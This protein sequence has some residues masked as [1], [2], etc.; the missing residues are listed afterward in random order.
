MSY[1][2]RFINDLK[3]LELDKAYLAD[4]FLIGNMYGIPRDVLE[5][6]QSA[7]YENQEKA[8]AGHVT[9]TMEPAGEVLGGLLAKKWGYDARGW[10]ICFS[11]DHLPFTQ[12]FEKE[13]AQIQQVKAQ[14]LQTL[15]R[16]GVS[17]E[18]INVFLDTD[19]KITQPEQA[20]TENL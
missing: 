9:Y 18:Q 5:A 17:I 12:V 1:I 7:T 13:R 15:L 3:V 4:Y 11:W 2:K 14:T 6:Y 10:K 19:F 16:L 20:Q 8:R